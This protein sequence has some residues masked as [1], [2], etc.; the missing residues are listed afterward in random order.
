V[1]P[2]GSGEGAFLDVNGMCSES[3]DQ[4]YSCEIKIGKIDLTGALNKAKL[5]TLETWAVDKG[6]QTGVI[7]K[8]Y[9]EQ[10]FNKLCKVP[11]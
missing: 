9:I 3:N 8:Q 7:T 1:V 2:Q 6:D 4:I 10:V 11:K 5:D